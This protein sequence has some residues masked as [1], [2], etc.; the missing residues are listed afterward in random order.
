MRVLR[1]VFVL[2]L[3]FTSFAYAREP[4]RVCGRKD[5]KSLS[6]EDVRA[7]KTVSL[8]GGTCSILYENLAADHKK[9]S[10]V[11]TEK[12]AEALRASGDLVSLPREGD[13]G[14][15]FVRYHPDF[16]KERRWTRPLAKAVLLDL[17]AEPFFEEFGVPLPINASLRT[18]EFQRRLAKKNKNA[19]SSVGLL[20]GSHSRGATFDIGKY[21]YPAWILGPKPE[22]EL[23]KLRKELPEKE[24]RLSNEEVMW[25]RTR[26]LVLESCGVIEAVEEFFQA[27]FHLEVIGDVDALYACFFPES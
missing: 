7:L 26:L 24:W 10:R 17:V 14:Y 27:N 12:D 1:T 19:A 15:E 4:T 6:F 3:F 9:W 22:S 2:L 18:V 20:P 13:F 5:W 25:L 23:R 21:R 11:F 8:K 16:D